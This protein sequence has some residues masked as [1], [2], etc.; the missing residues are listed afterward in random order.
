MMKVNNKRAVRNLADKSFRAAKTRNTIAVIA[1]ALTAILFTVLFTLGIGTV[2]NFQQS[3]MMQSGGSGHASF[4]YLTW[5]Q[6]HKISQHPDIEKI[7]YRV[8]IADSVDNPEFLK[9]H[10]ELYGANEESAE[11]N[12]WIPTTGRLPQAADEII[13]DT[14]SLDLLGIP[15]ELGQQITL[16]MTVKGQPVTRTFTLCGFWEA[17]GA[18]SVGFGVVSD[19]YLEAHQDELVNT[20]SQDF[21]MTGTVM[22]EAMFQNSWDLEGKLQKVL[23]ESGFSSDSKDENFIP[24]NVNWAYLSTNFT[25]DPITL[26]GAAAVAALIILTGYLI[27]Y[28]IFQIS[29]IRDIRFYGLLK[30]IGAT[31]RQIKG[32]LRRQALILSLMGIPIG[33]ILGFFVGKALLPMIL[34]QTI[35]AGMEAAVSFNPLIFMGAAA[36]ALITVL[37]STRKPA[38]I[39]ARVS[40]VEAVRYTESSSRIGKKLKRST[41]GGKLHRMA[42][43][44]LGRSK[45]RTVLVVLSLSLSLVLLNS[46]FTLSRS[47][48]MD[49]YMSQFADTDFLLADARY[50]SSEYQIGGVDPG[51]DAVSESFIETAQ[52]LDGFEQGGR[53]YA[54]PIVPVDYTFEG[55]NYRLAED[56]T[57]EEFNSILGDW[58]PKTLP[59]QGQAYSHLYG[60]EELPFSR[61]ELYDGETDPKALWE[62][63]QTGSYIVEGVEVDDNGRV[64]P[65]TMHFKLGETVTLYDQQGSAHQYEVIAHAAMNYYTNT[66]RYGTDLAFYTTADLF[67]TLSDPR[68]VMSYAFNAEDSKELAINQFLEEYTSQAEPLM[69]F[70]SKLSAQED[71]ESLRGMFL[72]VGGLLTFIIGLIG[73]LNFIN[74]VLTSIVTRKREFAMLQSIGMTGGQLKK[75]LV[76]EGCCYALATILVSLTVGALFS[77]TALRGLLGSIWFISY[78]FILWPMTVTWPVLIL[79]GILVPLIALKSTNRQSIVDRLRDEGE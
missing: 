27:I 78:R 19:A 26:G 54:D 12:F 16:E 7:G 24:A 14:E 29:V 40:P 53:L 58:L 60:L 31:G 25:P 6:Y 52:S 5:E 50:F 44:N 43:S 79:L 20:Y 67:K 22:A 21:N 28:N 15:H 77:A 23:E 36:F 41:D 33:L 61:L 9:R 71:F 2:E 69:S 4:K 72:A 68:L 70:E 59:A 51:E 55:E 66:T 48:D 18:M 65:D 64:E 1:I 32:I 57:L 30:T 46:V 62:K 17:K 73:V 35:M 63:M 45:K 13:M 38:K 49:K 39:A 76:L 56:G 42:L 10:V 74:S 37:I 34:D 8:L 3:T 75:L 11:M 47:F